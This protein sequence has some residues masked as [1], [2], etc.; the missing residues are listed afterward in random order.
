MLKSPWIRKPDFRNLPDPHYDQYWEGRGWSV[1]ESLKPREDIMLELIPVGSAVLDLGCGNSR[2][3]LE[4]V[5]KGCR[6]TVADVSELP[7]SE[8]RK[9]GIP[10][11]RVDL[12]AD[13]VCLP[14]GHFDYIIASEVL[15]HLRYPE[16]VV[17]A[18]RDRT[19]HLLIT[20]PNSAAYVFRYG[21]LVRGRFFTQW[22]R[23]PSEHLRFWSHLDFVDWITAHGYVVDRAIP[24][25]GFTLRGWLPF[26]PRWWKNFFAYRLV[27]DCR[28]APL[29]S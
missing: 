16:R 13:P 28:P 20:V 4:L 1:Q 10:G 21:L 29:A 12:E 25:D 3:P 23:H 17:T 11:I 5:A 27:Y 22:L 26:L 19:E 9:R 2:L 8:Y 24:A 6:V 18:L 14:E 15:E 7:L